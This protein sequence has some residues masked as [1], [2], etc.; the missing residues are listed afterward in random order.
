M[1][2]GYFQFMFP[3]QLYEKISDVDSKVT[4]FYEIYTN[5]KVYIKYIKDN[6]NLST[7]MVV[8]DGKSNDEDAKKL[9]TPKQVQAVCN[10]L[11][12]FIDDQQHQAETKNAPRY[13]LVAHR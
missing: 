7:I 12:L 3:S 11:N 13:G 4:N 8:D 6:D 10:K 1:E 5:I 2:D 9:K